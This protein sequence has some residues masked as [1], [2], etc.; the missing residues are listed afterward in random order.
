MPSDLREAHRILDL[1]IDKC[2]RP[3]GFKN[4][5][6]RLECLFNLYEEMV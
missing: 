1:E 4:D 3:N 6:E 2:Y 5:D